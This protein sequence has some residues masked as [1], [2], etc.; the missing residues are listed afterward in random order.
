MNERGHSLV[1]LAVAL[2]LLALLMAGLLR[3]L[4]PAHGALARA[5]ASLVAQRSLRRAQDA[6]VED[7]QNA[8][9]AVPLPGRGP[10]GPSLEAVE[11]SLVLRRDEVRSETACLREAT[12]D[13]PALLLAVRRSFSLEA[14]IWILVE[15]DAW[16]ALPLAERANLDPDRWNEVRTGRVPLSHGAGAAV[17]FLRP[18]GE[19]AYRLGRHRGESGLLR[20]D[21]AGTR[22]VGRDITEFRASVLA[23][24]SGRPHV[25]EIH[26]EARAGL[27]SAEV[28]RRTGFRVA[29]RG[30]GGW[31]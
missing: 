25:V 8:G 30:A 3:W 24:Q 15:D 5:G 16:E 22:V 1:E 21:G 9:F 14:G 18:W 17:G 6:L 23:G 27:G 11:G 13:G 4:G 29:V 19:V 31:P 12:G 26:L 20:Q 7:V 10:Q 28:R 2:G